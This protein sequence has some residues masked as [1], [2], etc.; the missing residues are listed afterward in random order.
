M[1][2]ALASRAG[3]RDPMHWRIIPIVVCAALACRLL[4]ARS[5][6]PGVG[7]ALVALALLLAA[8]G[9][10]FHATADPRLRLRRDTFLGL[11][12]GML[13]AVLSRLLW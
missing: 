2:V 3:G 6:L 4:L 1:H 9:W 13:L 10:A 7:A 5:H 11:A 8:G 12:A